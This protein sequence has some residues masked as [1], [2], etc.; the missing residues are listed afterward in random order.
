MSDLRQTTL[1]LLWLVV[2]TAAASPEFPLTS[3]SACDLSATLKK[4]TRTWTQT[5]RTTHEAPPG[6]GEGVLTPDFWSRMPTGRSG[7]KEAPFRFFVVPTP[8]LS[9]DGALQV[10]FCAYRGDPGE[11]VALPCVLVGPG[12][13]LPLHWQAPGVTVSCELSWE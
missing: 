13:T 4:R 7:S 9:S 5:S 6:S 12:E 2:P 8:T 10:N 11:I 1:L 3:V